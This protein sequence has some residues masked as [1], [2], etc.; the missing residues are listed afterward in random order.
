VFA[1][2]KDTTELRVYIDYR[3]LNKVTVKNR[4]LLS[5][6]DSLIDRV[7]SAK[8]FT[9]LDLIKGYYEIR[10]KPGDEYKTAF[11]TL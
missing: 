11:K 2:K 8:Y 4:Y 6:I 9:K 5:L 3:A 1:S 7:A 10:I